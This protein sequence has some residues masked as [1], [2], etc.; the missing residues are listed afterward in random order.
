MSSDWDIPTL[1]AS[2]Q[3]ETLPGPVTAWGSIGRTR[4]MTGS[5]HFYTS[6]R[7]FV[8]VAAR[9]EVLVS[10]GCAA[11]VETNWSTHPALSRAEV[12]WGIYRKRRLARLWQDAG[13]RVAVDLNVDLTFADLALIGVPRGWR[14]YATRCHR[15][16]GLEAIS[17]QYAIA[18]LHAGTED[19]AF[20]VF[21]GGKAVKAWCLDQGLSWMPERADVVRGRA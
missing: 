17:S 2:M 16:G 3:A 18:L 14:C 7:R 19:I 4:R 5:Y 8:A 6:D 11:V 21:G 13:I 12:L 20:T 10:T 15:G 1:D 9:P